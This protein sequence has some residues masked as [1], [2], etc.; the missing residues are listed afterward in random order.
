MLRERIVNRNTTL[1]VEY[2]AT[3][4]API[5]ITIDDPDNQCDCGFS[6]DNAMIE[7]TIDGV[8]ELHTH[9]TRFLELYELNKPLT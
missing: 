5:Y 7:L 6:G 9:L 2:E 4:T 8:R 1:V 3:P